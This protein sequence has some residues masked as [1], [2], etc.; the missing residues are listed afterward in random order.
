MDDQVEDEVCRNI[1]KCGKYLER[2]DLYM[3]LGYP[4]K[5]VEKEF[6]KFVNRLHRSGLSTGKKMRKGWQRSSP[7]ETDGKTGARKL[8]RLCGVYFEVIGF[9]KTEV[10]L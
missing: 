1:I 6:S 7:W 9:E 4:A 5:A 2:L 3:R 8:W 10:S